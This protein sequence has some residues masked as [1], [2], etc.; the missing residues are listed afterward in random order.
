MRTVTLATALAL[1]V[2][3]TAGGCSDDKSGQVGSGG[4]GTGGADVVGDAQGTDTASD[5]VGSDSDGAVQQDGGDATTPED[6]AAVDAADTASPADADT[7]TPADAD[8]TQPGS[9]CVPLSW[10]CDDLTH[11]VQCNSQGQ[12]Y[13]APVACGNEEICRNG[14]CVVRCPNDP[15]FGVYVGCEFWATD[16]ENY[17]D[18]TLN[19]T[20]ENLPWAMVVSNPG[21]NAVRVG[22]EMPPL[23]TYAPAD[24]VVPAGESRSFQL[25]NINVQGTSVRPKGVHLTASGPVLAYMFNPWDNRFSNDASLLLPDPLLGTEYAILSW[26]TSPIGVVQIIPGVTPPANQNGYF[27]VIAAYDD[28]HVTFQVT[29][30]VKAS[31]SIPAMSPGQTHTVT[32]RRGDVLNVEADPDQLFDPMDITGSRVTSDKPIAV[33]GGHEEA[34]I[35]DRIPD[36]ENGQLTSPCCA[37]HLEEQMLPIGVLGTHYFAVKSAPRGT[38]VIEPDVWRIQAVEP[39]VTVTTTPAQPG[40]GSF[41]LQNIGDFK[42]ISTNQSFEIDA[43][44]KVQVGQYLVTRDNTEAFTG[45][46]SLV[47]LV[48]A[49]RFRK[50]YV[51]SVPDGYSKLWVSIVRPAGASL[52]LDGVA[53]GATGFAPLGASGWSTG[54]LPLT[55][56]QHVISGDQDFGLTVYGY[57]NAVSFSYIGGLKGPGE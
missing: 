6:T 56:G 30:K 42:E 34:V 11:R 41:T 44:G 54:Y 48:P 14:A 38:S 18:P 8:T 17:P 27:T 32:L 13:D 9:Y 26:P 25:P 39:G 19:P 49:D 35:G 55:A 50:D 29:A 47:L 1:A 4:D 52:T 22:F 37:D 53:A 33:F 10:R 46:P 28:T 7:S 16:L 45:D 12:A 15:K 31:G 36:G 40:A 24:D 57:S 3:L 43:T 20:P 51:I 21:A 23:F 5:A 2:A